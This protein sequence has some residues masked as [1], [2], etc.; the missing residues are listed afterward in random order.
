M[1]NVTNAIGRK[2]PTQLKGWNKVCTPYKGPF[3]IVKER[4]YRDRVIP[5]MRGYT[6]GR[7]KIAA[8]L[9]EAIERSGLSDGMTI[10]FHHHLRN[11]DA[12]L[13]MVL[14]VIASMGIKD[15]TLAPS[16]LTDAHQC[17]VD[18]IR[19]GVISRI[20]TSGLRGKL[21]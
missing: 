20:T 7:K 10:S 8:N 18:Y 2:V 19:S 6:P 21:G 15:L 11:G 14:D 5:P 4:P 9:K 17:V 3:E 12:V 16:S 1:S 13:P